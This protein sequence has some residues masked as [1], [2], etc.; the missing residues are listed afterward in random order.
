MSSPFSRPFDN[1]YSRLPADFFSR[2]KPDS[3]SGPVLIKANHCLARN[4]GIDPDWLESEQGVAFVAGNYL[5]QGADP[6]AAVYAGHQFGGFSPRLG[7][8]RAVLIGEILAADG[9][10]YDLQLKGS[11][12]T[13]YSRGGDGRAPLGPVLREYV[14]SEA[15][16]VLG[17]PTTRALAAVLS[18][19]LVMRETPLPGAVLARVA[20]SHLRIGTIQYF[21]ARNDLKSLKVLVD[22]VIK[23]HYPESAS[24]ASPVLAMLNGII[25]KQAELIAQWQAL[26]FIHGVMNTDNMLLSGETIDYGPCAFLD[27]FEPGKTFSS[28]DHGGRYAYSNQPQIAHWNLRVLAQSLLPLINDNQ[29]QAL[30]EAQAAIDAFPSQY[31][32]AYL[33]RMRAKLGLSDADGA[34]VEL[35]QDLLKLMQEEQTDYTLTFRVLGDLAGPDNAAEQGVHE[36]I[37]L[38]ARFSGWI[39][40]WKSQ[41]ADAKQNPSDIQS[42]MYRNNPAFIPR[43]HLL[44]EVISAATKEMNFEPFETLMDVLNRP[45]SYCNSLRRF[46]RPP[47]ADQVVKQTFCGT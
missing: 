37:E 15:M 1:S 11:G 12:R 5:P 39:K 4:L 14:L 13:A 24:S 22:Y 34:A 45:F 20:K 23:R 3:V 17:V 35:I 31:Q 32:S 41:I 27:E 16:A 25:Q 7:D 30:A 46:A 42:L 47:H 33:D 28:I 44:E 29:D 10:R 21:A 26:G 6:I 43:N 38:P 18:G 2:Q 36:L 8:G 9:Q 40:R 19:D